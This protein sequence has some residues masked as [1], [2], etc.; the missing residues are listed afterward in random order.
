[1]MLEGVV[2]STVY[3]MQAVFVSSHNWRYQSQARR[4]EFCEKRT[5][6]FSCKFCNVYFFIVELSAG[7]QLLKLCC[8]ILKK[9]C[10]KPE[11]KLQA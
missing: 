3:I 9:G 10:G 5:K 11:Q 4:D 1:M 2:A 7:H 6:A 8:S